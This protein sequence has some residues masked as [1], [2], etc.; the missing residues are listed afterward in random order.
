METKLN[1]WLCR[2]LT[3]MGKTLLVNA[4][5]ISKMYTQPQC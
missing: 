2:D 1:L 4:L 3:L 5:G